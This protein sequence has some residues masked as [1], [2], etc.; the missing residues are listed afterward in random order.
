[1]YFQLAQL[2]C[3]GISKSNDVPML[4]QKNEKLKIELDCWKKKLVDVGVSHGIRNFSTTSILS[5]A[6]NGNQL[7]EKPAKTEVQIKS[8]EAK[9]VQPKKNAG[10]AIFTV[11]G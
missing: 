11:M 10:N 9:K 8:K 2:E 6:N 7:A 3:G 4:K 5:E 1:M